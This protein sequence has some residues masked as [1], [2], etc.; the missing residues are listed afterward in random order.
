MEGAPT[1]QA[2]AT[3]EQ[4]QN[5]S[6]WPLPGGLNAS[7]EVIAGRADNVLV[8]PV[9]ALRELDLGQYAVMVMVDGK[10]QMRQVEVGLMDYAYAEIVSGLEQG[11][12]V[13]TGILGTE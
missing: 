1:I 5:Y 4:G 7:V 2:L 13:S 6:I 9:E 12:Q 10:P 8:V 11:D 3:L